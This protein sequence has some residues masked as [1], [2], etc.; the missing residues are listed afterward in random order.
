MAYADLRA[1]EELLRDMLVE[2]QVW[3]AIVANPSATWEELAV[4]LDAGTVAEGAAAEAVVYGAFAEVPDDP[5]YKQRPRANVRQMADDS[6]ER[7]SGSGFTSAKGL[8]LIVDLNIPPAYTTDISAALLDARRKA[9]AL[10]SDILQLE[11]G[12]GRLDFTGLQSL[13]VGLADPK[14]W[15]GDQFQILEWVFSFEGTV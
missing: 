9:L 14:E 7:T 1:P 12:A 3:R 15:G 4:I 5:K 10:E 8:M 11:R 13:V 6:W 2:T